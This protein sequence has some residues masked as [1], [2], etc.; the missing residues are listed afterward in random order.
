[1]L[2]IYLSTILTTKGTFLHDEITS[3]SGV[4]RAMLH[5]SQLLV[6]VDAEYDYSDA[7]GDY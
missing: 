7:K 4:T 2:T 3:A 1:M 6:L 5:T